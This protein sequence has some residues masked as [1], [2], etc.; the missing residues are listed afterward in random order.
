MIEKRQS[1]VIAVVQK[2]LYQPEIRIM[3]HVYIGVG[4][5]LIFFGRLAGF[6]GWGIK[7]AECVIVIATATI[8]K[9]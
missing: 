9:L 2:S 5:I 7:A 1:Y 4:F 6:V 8:L 3:L